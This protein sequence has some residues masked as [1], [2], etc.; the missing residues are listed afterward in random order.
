MAAEPNAE[1][2]VRA[3]NDNS[4]WRLILGIQAAVL[5]ENRRA[6]KEE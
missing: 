3:T 1:M 2:Y 4:A 5:E 6:N